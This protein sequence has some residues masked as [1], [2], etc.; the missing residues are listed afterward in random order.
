[1]TPPEAMQRGDIAI[2]ASQENVSGGGAMW[3][4]DSLQIWSLSL[5]AYGSERTGYAL[6]RAQLMPFLP[7]PIRHGLIVIV[8]IAGYQLALLHVVAR[9]FDDQTSAA[10]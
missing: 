6:V 9:C 1:M 3:I 7:A 5:R 4:G 10:R 2:V 8:L